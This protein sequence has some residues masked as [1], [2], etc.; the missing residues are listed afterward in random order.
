MLGYIELY[1]ITTHLNRIVHN[2]LYLYTDTRGFS[3]KLLK[4]YLI[5]IIYEQRD[6]VQLVVINIWIKI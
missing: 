4:S 5:A 1:N 3:V 2:R 6:I